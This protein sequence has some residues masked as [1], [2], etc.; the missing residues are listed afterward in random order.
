M[1]MNRFGELIAAMR[2]EKNM[3][4]TELAQTLG[5]SKQAVSNWERGKR[6]PDVVLIEDL[7]RTLG[8]S[9][10]ELF[11]GERIPES[12]INDTEVTRLICAAL[13]AQKKELSY[14][15]RLTT[16][17]LVA[18]TAML[19]LGA[20]YAFWFDRIILINFHSAAITSL[21]AAAFGAAARYFI[22][23]K[24]SFYKLSLAAMT[25]WIVFET[26]SA[27]GFNKD[28]INIISIICFC[29]NMAWYILCGLAAAWITHFVMMLV[30]HKTD[31]NL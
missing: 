19:C 16:L 13:K 29:A 24:E 6:F 25:V 20:G 18:L 30:Q 26:V 5:I 22:A 12:D 21:F 17:M 2:R 15:W 3:T 14:R 1:N 31:K 7:A 4:Q 23:D 10:A 27:I 8:V 9:P 28:L 11:K